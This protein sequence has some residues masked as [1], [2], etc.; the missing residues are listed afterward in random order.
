MISGALLLDRDE[1]WIDTFKKRITKVLIIFFSINVVLY[2]VQGLVGIKTGEFEWSISDFVVGL[3]GNTLVGSR[4]YWYLYAYL[5][6]LFMLPFFRRAVKNIALS[7]VTAVLVLHFIVFSFLPVFNLIF[8]KTDV[9]FISL[10]V[11]FPF[12]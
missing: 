1:K 6:F 10:S 2:V 7:E 8:A 3:F 11:V 5:G 9:P 12:R 4:T